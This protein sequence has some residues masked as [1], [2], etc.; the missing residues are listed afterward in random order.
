MDVL[1]VLDQALKVQWRRCAADL[2]RQQGY[3]IVELLLN[4]Q[5]VQHL[6]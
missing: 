1:P 3:F 2:E 4:G 6:E 5:P